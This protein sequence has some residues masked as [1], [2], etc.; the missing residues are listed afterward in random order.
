MN[1]R[2]DVSVLPDGF[3]IEHSLF[4]NSFENTELY[5]LDKSIIKQRNGWDYRPALNHWHFNDG[6]MVLP[7]GLVVEVDIGCLAKQKGRT[8]NNKIYFLDSFVGVE[9]LV[10]AH[11]FSGFH[12][13]I[14]GVKILGVTVWHGP[15]L[16][17]EVIEL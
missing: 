5:E 4:G 11:D 17:M 13:H 6:K 14:M 15:Q 7:D 2:I 8:L 3:L 16:G 1:K 10:L 9:S 12:W